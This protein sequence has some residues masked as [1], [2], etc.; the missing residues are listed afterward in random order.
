[1]NLT[2]RI[3]NTQ[4]QGVQSWV[5]S[6][7]AMTKCVSRRD[8]T[9]FVRFP[10]GQTGAGTDLPSFGKCKPER[11]QACGA[12]AKTNRSGDR[13]AET[14]ENANRSEDR[15]AKTSAK[16][17]RLSGWLHASHDASNKRNGILARRH[18]EAIQN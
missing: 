9:S 7:L 15:L 11:E 16:T 8:S 17:N 5:A 4:Q 13:L 2:T 3:G 10:K 1:M 18:D 14:S 6:C 12:S